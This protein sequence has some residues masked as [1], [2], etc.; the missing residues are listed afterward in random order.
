MPVYLLTEGKV[1]KTFT[2][3]PRSPKAGV[4]QSQTEYDL[5]MR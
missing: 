3:G 2:L 5:S 1:Y 4:K